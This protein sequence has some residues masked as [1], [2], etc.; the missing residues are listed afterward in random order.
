M[1]IEHVLLQNSSIMKGVFCFDIIWNC[2]LWLFHCIQNHPESIYWFET[3]PIAPRMGILLKNAPILLEICSS[4]ENKLT[5]CG[6]VAM[7][8][9]HWHCSTDFSQFNSISLY[10]TNAHAVQIT[11][12]IG[13]WRTCFNPKRRK[14]LHNLAPAFIALPCWHQ[15][16]ALDDDDRNH[17]C[18]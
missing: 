11:H 12:C 8:V 15:T 4:C 6:I 2:K 5:D 13:A 1:N 16:S 7:Q 18:T 10:C 3:P 14:W 17:H 9:L